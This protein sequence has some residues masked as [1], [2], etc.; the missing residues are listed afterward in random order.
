M[1]ALFTAG[2]RAK[3][4]ANESGFYPTDFSVKTTRQ[5]DDVVGVPSNG[6]APQHL[7]TEGH[8]LQ[9]TITTTGMPIPTA[10]GAYQGLCALDDADTIA[11]LSNLLD[12]E[13]FGLVLSQGTILSRDPEYKKARNGTGREFSFTFMHNPYMS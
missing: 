13:V 1:N 5:H 4:L 7:Y 10:G 11:S 12:D 3:S 9:T 2:T 8:T 6:T